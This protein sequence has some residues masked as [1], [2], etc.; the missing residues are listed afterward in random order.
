MPFD[1]LEL[2]ENYKK[3]ILQLKKTIEESLYKNS[4]G[5]DL[6]LQD[7]YDIF[8]RKKHK[9]L[10]T[11]LYNYEIKNKDVLTDNNTVIEDREGISKK[12]I[13][14]H[15]NILDDLDRIYV[16]NNSYLFLREYNNDFIYQSEKSYL[17]EFLH[18]YEYKN[19]I[20]NIDEF[21]IIRNSI[22][23]LLN[24]TITEYNTFVDSIRIVLTILRPILLIHSKQLDYNKI[25]YYIEEEDLKTAIENI[26][27][28]KIEFPFI[29]SI[30]GIYYKYS[31]ILTEIKLLEK[32]YKTII[33]DINDKNNYLHVLLNLFIIL[34]I[35]LQ[36][37]IIHPRLIDALQTVKN[38]YDIA[39]S[40]ELTKIE[41]K[42]INDIL[43]ELKDYDILQLE[44]NFIEISNKSLELSKYIKSYLHLKIEDFLI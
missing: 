11:L 22:M 6:I 24:S 14:I 38:E 44:E 13:D 3:K 41:K 7:I 30:G 18:R 9:E 28:N 19:I 2:K 1:E 12:I 21:N 34:N 33:E 37:Y 15:K 17:D 39:K 23:N 43:Y 42:K 29:N 27:K 10:L 32:P 5:N 31:K 40:C 36:Y 8:I 16:K 25:A 20:E 26:F 35:M 4:I